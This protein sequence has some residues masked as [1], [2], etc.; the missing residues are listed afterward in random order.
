MTS[1]CITDEQMAELVEGNLSSSEQTRLLKHV[2]QCP[3]CYD[4][5]LTMLALASYNDVNDQD[6]VYILLPEYP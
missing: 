2:I 4:Q 5:Y 1:E 6:D 3:E